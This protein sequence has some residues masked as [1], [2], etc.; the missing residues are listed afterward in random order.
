MDGAYGHGHF[1]YGPYVDGNI[2]RDLPSREF[3]AGHF[4]KVPMLVD[5][6]QYEGVSFS[7][8]SM[9]TVEELVHDVQTQFPYSDARFIER[10]LA[11]YP[12]NDYNSTFWQRVAWFG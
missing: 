11:L 4:S 2:I 5:R 9:T 8:R 12:L 6:E 7:N 3:K 1:F 10:L